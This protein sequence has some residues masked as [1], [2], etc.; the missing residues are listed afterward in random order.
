[1]KKEALVIAL[2][3]VL[4]I[5]VSY[6]SALTFDLKASYSPN[7]NILGEIIGN[8]INPVQK[9]QVELKRGDVR[10]PFTGD[11][12]KVGDKVYLWCI[13]PENPNNYT[14]YIYNITTNVNGFVK[15]VDIIRNFSVSGNLTD[16]KITPGFI[17][18]NE[19]FSVDIFLYEDFDRDI[20]ASLIG[21]TTLHPGENKLDF[22]IDKFI[23]ENFI[24]I[25]IGKYGLPAYILGAK[26]K[27]S[28]KGNES[29]TIE[30]SPAKIQR[31]ISISSRPVFLI[32][33]ANQGNETLN[34]IKVLYDDKYFSVT[35]KT[36]NYIRPNK[37]AIVNV[38]FVG[39]GDIADYI[40]FVGESFNYS[41]PITINVS[42]TQLNLTGNVSSKTGYYCSELDGIVCSADEVCSETTVVSLDGNCCKGICSAIK[43][44][45]GSSWIGYLLG[46]VV[47]AGLGYLVY[48][49][50]KKGK[51]PNMQD[52]FKKK[53]AAAETQ[54]KKAPPVSS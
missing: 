1:M 23:G 10:M 50:K 25:S 34:N 12:G 49:Y 15:K 30:F 38:S 26:N 41:L 7:E 32:E 36:I 43:S 37:T 54:Q 35:P 18:T 31:I 53:V 21:Y 22:K 20:N 14:L 4:A 48:M 52:I 27:S 46:L 9:E 6:V 24:T 45:G 39:S 19:N 13:A 44:G 3:I 17:S 40:Y 29:S 51:K 11:I 28:T 5:N 42:S 33:I 8:V 47:L 2:I 16:Y